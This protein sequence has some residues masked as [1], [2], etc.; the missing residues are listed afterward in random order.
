MYIKKIWITIG[1][2]GILAGIF[3]ANYVYRSI[4]YPNTAFKSSAKVVYIPTG[5]PYHDL[6]RTLKPLLK[7]AASFHKIATKKGYSKQVKPGRY[8]IKRGSSNN[9]IINTLRSENAPIKLTFNNQER[10]ENLAARVAMQIEADSIALIRAFRAEDFLKKNKFD[11]E[12][13]LAMYIP[14]QYELYW[15][16]SAI[17]FRQRMLKEYKLFWNAKRIKKAKQI[18]LTPIE[19]NII[20]SIVQK[21]TVKIDERP[22][23]A[24]VYINRYREGWKLQADPT[25]I[26]ALKKQTQD[27]NK[28]IRRVLYK[29]L[30]IDNPYNTYKYKAL[31]PGPIAMPDISSIDAVLN[32]K[33]HPYFFFVADLKRRGYHKFARTLSEHNRNR[34]HYSKWIE[35]KGIR[36]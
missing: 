19:V 5:T 8:I 36:R 12:N 31:P 28:S 11:S 23:V 22:I 21:E 18:N 30:K 27:W 26:Y 32:H 7:D 2:F 35:N 3:F 15:N 9:A 20:A 13:A 33:K 17:G 16:T 34:K 25:V 4:F 24:G 6:L 14:N 10:L 29:D 1:L